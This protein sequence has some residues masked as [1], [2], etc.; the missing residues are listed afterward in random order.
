MLSW[1]VSSCHTLSWY[2]F[3]ESKW[4]RVWVTPTPP[5][6][7]PLISQSVVSPCLL[8]TLWTRSAHT[9]NLLLLH[10]CVTCDKRMCASSRRSLFWPLGDRR[11]SYAMGAIEITNFCYVIAI[12]SP[13]PKNTNTDM[14]IDQPHGHEETWGFDRSCWSCRE[15]RVILVGESTQADIGSHCA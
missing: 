6:T 11:L 14:T 5:S 15:R 4:H 2:A 7:H 8:S 3:T 9:E 13:L 1:A 10:K 12:T